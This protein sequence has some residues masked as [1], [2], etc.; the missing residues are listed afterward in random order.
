MRKTTIV[1]LFILLAAAFLG[2]QERTVK[3]V[4]FRPVSIQQIKAMVPHVVSLPLIIGGDRHRIAIMDIEDRTGSITEKTLEA[5][6]E[7]LRGEIVS[8]DKVYLVL[9]DPEEKAAVKKEKQD[10]WKED[11][12]AKQ[13][14]QPGE[15][16]PADT[17]VMPTISTFGKVHIFT[18]ELVDLKREA[19]IA[20]SKSE[21]DGTEEGLRSAI[22]EAVSSL[23]KKILK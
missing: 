21:Y 4:A 6:R 15:A 3:P 22:K 5:A 18:L 12:N 10:T 16:A 7:Y 13:H 20:G 2:A 11:Y 17:V 23:V 9:K 14:V 19:V 8:T 1:S